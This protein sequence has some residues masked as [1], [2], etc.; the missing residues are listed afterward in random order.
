MKHF[1]CRYQNKIYKQASLKNHIRKYF[2]LF[3]LASS[4]VLQSCI[5]IVEE[6]IVNDDQSGS[7]SLSV[8]TR[9]NNPLFALISQYADMSFMDNIKA[10]TEQI[11]F[12]LKNQE[13]IENVQLKEKKWSAGLELSF[14]FENDKKLNNALYATT[15]MQKTFFQPNIYKIRRNKFVRKNT[16]GWIQRLIEQEKENIPDEA[17][18]DLIEL[19]SV[20][21]IP[22]PAKSIYTKC[23]IST[24]NNNQTFTTSNYL[25]EILNEKINTRIKIRL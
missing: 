16:T 22:V 14:D 24:S 23:K 3:I 21:Q 18:F 1:V 5:E 25:S 12:I 2:L 15:G 8:S 19:K 9:T 7:I 6:V 20:Y 17:V 10:N 13:G 4:L 11:A